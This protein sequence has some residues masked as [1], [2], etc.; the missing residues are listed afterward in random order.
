MGN[1]EKMKQNFLLLAIIVLGTVIFSFPYTRMGGLDERG[2]LLGAGLA[3]HFMHIAFAKELQQ[4]FPPRHP[5]FAGEALYNYNY[6]SDLVVAAVSTM[7]RQDA[8]ITQ[9][10]IMPVVYGALFGISSWALARSLKLSFISQIFLLILTYF[11]S[12]LSFVADWF[13]PKKLSWDDA[14][15]LNQPME[16]SSNPPLILSLVLLQFILSIFF[17]LDKKSSRRKLFAFFCLLVFLPMVKVISVFAVYPVFAVVILGLFLKKQRRFALNVS[18]IILIALLSSLWILLV[19]SH[20]SGGLVWQPLQPLS[21]LIESP[22]FTERTKD[23]VLKYYYYR[24]TGNYLRVASIYLLFLAVFVVGNLGSRIVGVFSAMTSVWHRRGFSLIS[25]ALTC[26]AL[27]TFSVPMFFIL[28]TGGYNI[29]Y[30]YYYSVFIVNIF[31]ATG[32][33]SLF[34]GGNYRKS[35]ILLSF[36]LITFPG[37]LGTF[38]GQLRGD[39]RVYAADLVSDLRELKNKLPNEGV[40]LLDPSLIK[41]Q[42]NLVSALTGRRVYLEGLEYPRIQGHNVTE[43]LMRLRNG[44]TALSSGEKMTAVEEILGISEIVAV[45]IPLNK[46]LDV[47]PG[48]MK[49]KTN[50]EFKM[51]IVRNDH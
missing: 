18:V 31:S 7:T 51:Y 13:V 48:L 4:H 8:I 47:H 22:N 35:F 39:P 23:L 27:L 3:D 20:N 49:W 1:A 28:K 21:R 26:S 50:S 33:G 43:R 17:S 37:S 10:K 5:L 36:F 42:D 6:G 19:N 12:S 15:G 16:Y 9:F 25:M 45:I 24:E 46:N 29:N 11:G 32:W 34:H 41:E 2:N 38:L 30:L 40:I 44:M 14:L